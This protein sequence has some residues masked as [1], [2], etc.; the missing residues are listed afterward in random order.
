MFRDGR[1][2]RTLLPIIGRI[3]ASST[4]TI[5]RC[6]VSMCVAI[7]M[8]SV[9][10]LE[11]QY[12]VD[13]DDGDAPG[14]DLP[15]DDEHLV[16][17]A[18]DAVCRLSAGV[19]ERERVLVDAAE[20]LLDVRH[21]LLRSH[22]ENHAWRRGEAP[23]FVSLSLAIHAP[24]PR[25]EGLVATGRFDLCEDPRSLKRL[26]SSRVHLRAVGDQVEDKPLR[27]GQVSRPERADPIRLES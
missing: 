23:H 1:G 17:R 8:S 6:A 19:F 26:R 13:E 16:H 22:A 12:F 24:D 15:V 25:P 10:L 20:T 4:R 5:S 18:V 14:C 3:W 7:V 21:E 27:L 2:S 11:A 9:R